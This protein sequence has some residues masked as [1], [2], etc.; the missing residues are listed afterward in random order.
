MII[1]K[2]SVLPNIV[3]FKML[4]KKLKEQKVKYF[5]ASLKSTN[6]YVLNTNVR[7]IYFS[8]DCTA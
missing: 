4:K 8:N 3:W 1:V 2:D 7:F 6:N 5:F